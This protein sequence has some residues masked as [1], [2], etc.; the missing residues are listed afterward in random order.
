MYKY[1]IYSFTV[2][3]STVYPLIQCKI[4]SYTVP[5]N[6]V[7]HTLLYSTVQ[8][9]TVQ[10]TLLYSTVQY[11][12]YSYINLKIKQFILY[13]FLCIICIFE[14]AANFCDLFFYILVVD[15]R[16]FSVIFKLNYFE[17]FCTVSLVARILNFVLLIFALDFFWYSKFF[18]WKNEMIKNFLI[19]IIIFCVNN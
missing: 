18:E 2:H 10:N 12:I 6:T 5:Y 16:L 7:Q 14:V 19:I 3:S 17:K 1:N 9:R 13:I 4:C 8:Y 11:N 15:I